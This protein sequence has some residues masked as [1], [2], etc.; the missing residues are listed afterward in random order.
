MKQ[1]NKGYPTE[2]EIQQW[3]KESPDED[4]HIYL[5]RKAYERGDNRYTE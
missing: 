4:P 2:Q 5:I 1:N 3:I